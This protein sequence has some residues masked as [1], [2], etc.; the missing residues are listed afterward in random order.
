MST[1]EKRSMFAFIWHGFFLAL[2]MAMLD[3]NTVFPTLINTLSTNKFIFGALYSIMLGTPLIFN[4]LFSHYLSSKP[5]KKKYLLL[6]MYIRSLS[7][8]GMG[9]FTYLLSEQYSNIVL[10]SF[11][12]FVFL[13][14]VSA[15]FAGLSYSDL[16]AKTIKDSRRTRLFSMKQ[17]S[18]SLASLFGGFIIARI[19][20]LGIAFPLNYTLSLVIGF[21][22]LIIASAGFYFMH[23]PPSEAMKQRPSL[24]AY[25][26]NI[27]NILRKD[28]SF[29]YYIIVENLSSFSVM[30]L[31]FYIVYAK[32]VITVDNSFIGVYLIVQISGTIFSNIIWGI[33]GE[34][35]NA[36]T[37]V[38][39]CILL[40]VLNPIL[41][42]TL[43]QFGAYPFAVVF[44]IMG[45]MISGRRIGFEPTLLDITPHEQRMEYLGIRGT[46]NIAIIILPLVGAL[47]IETIGYIVAFSTVSVVMMIA[48]FLLAKVSDKQVEAYCQ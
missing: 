26:R 18:G 20:A 32:E 23:E 14:S 12:V 33:I 46:L 37:I 38:R 43:G 11:F 36:K 29:R 9:L 34:R 40:G 42:I 13:F 4:I 30:I 44:F 6:G 41:A 24:V 45:F 7:F 16:V 5:F 15:G 2:T 10:Y 3:L 19:F 22:G 8:L 17:F 21:I 35:F 27:P 1:N 25:I 31:P 47:L 28:S 48:F 39:F